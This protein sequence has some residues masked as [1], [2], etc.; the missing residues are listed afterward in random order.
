MANLI[1]IKYYALGE[2]GATELVCLY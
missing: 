1:K 2:N